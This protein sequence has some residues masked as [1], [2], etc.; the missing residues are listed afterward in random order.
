MNRIANIQK[1]PLKSVFTLS[2]P[3]F[4]VLIL[5]SFYSFIDAYWISGLGP[6]AIIAIGYVLNLWYCIQDL[7]DGIGRSCNIIMS[8]SFGAN[9]Y[10]NTT[11]LHVMDYS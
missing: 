8:T 5:Q 11:M 3:I 2:I 1:Y 7:G 4:L 10:E 6:D 9:D